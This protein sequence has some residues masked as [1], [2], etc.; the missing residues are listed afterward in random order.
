M[1]VTTYPLPDSY[2]YG[3]GPQ[4]S[5]LSAIGSALGGPIGGLATGLIGGIF[6]AR[7]ARRQNRM[8]REM[9]REQMRFQERMSNTAAQRAAKDLEAAGLNR[10]LALGKPASTPSGSMAPVVNEGQM[11]ISSALQIQRQQK[12]LNVLDAQERN[13]RSDSNQKDAQ[14][15][16][17]DHQTQ[18]LI[19]QTW[20]IQ[21]EREGVDVQNELNR[22][23]IPG[24]QAEADFWQ[25]LERGELTELAKTVPMVGPILGRVIDSYLRFRKRKKK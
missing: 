4:T 23:R 1:P 3:G 6:S 2:G 13:L 11:A 8:Q 21:L 9:M 17:I 14:A 15:F 12:E 16:N 22:L 25:W 20:K 10:I 5:A 24:L 7:S 19:E 18:Q